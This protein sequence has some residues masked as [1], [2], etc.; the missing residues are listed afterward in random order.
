MASK[1]GTQVYSI[2][3]EALYARLEG[4][5]SKRKRVNFEI[6]VNN[7]IRKY[8]SEYEGM[9]AAWFQLAKKVG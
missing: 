8:N 3:L 1:Y 5:D 4:I 9:R 6:F 7:Y 2:K